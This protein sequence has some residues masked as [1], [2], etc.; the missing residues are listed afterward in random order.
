MMEKI[1]IFQN[2]KKVVFSVKRVSFFGKFSGLML[3]T[4]HTKRLLFDFKTEKI[5]A[6]HSFFVFF[7][8]LILWLDKDKNVI[9][10]EIVKPFRTRVVPNKRFRYAVEIPMNKE[11]KKII[12]LFVEKRKI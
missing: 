1:S 10:K 6:M 7:S 3:R 11:N 5:R 8:F 12:S 2:N 9:D 4:R